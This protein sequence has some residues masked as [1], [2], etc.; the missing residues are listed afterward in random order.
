MREFQLWLR[1]CKLGGLTNQMNIKSFQTS[2]IQTNYRTVEI[3][4]ITW[5]RVRLDYSD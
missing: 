3:V 1:R 5:K 4:N 2:T